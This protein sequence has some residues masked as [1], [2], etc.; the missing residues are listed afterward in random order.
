MPDKDSGTPRVFLVRHGQTE[1]SQVCIHPSP[2]FTIRY[3]YTRVL[4]KRYPERKTMCI[5]F[6]DDGRK[7]PQIVH[8]PGTVVHNA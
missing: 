4:E 3:V 2:G 8:D 6:Y 7:E 1:W 5:A